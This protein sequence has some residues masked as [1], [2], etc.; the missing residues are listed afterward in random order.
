VIDLA[1]VSAGGGSI[2]WV[3]RG[4]SIKVGPASAGAVPGPAAY[5]R[6]GTEATV[7]DANIVLGYLDRKALLGGRLP[8][9]LAGAE[10]AISRVGAKMGFNPVETA[11]RIIEVVDANMAEALRIVSVERGYDPRSFALI[12]FGGAGPV[13]AAALAEELSIPEVIIPPA[14]G[15]FSALGLVASDLKRDYARTLYAE[16]EDLEPQR[17]EAV[18]VSMASS[19]LAML[20]DAR[21]PEAQREIR[22]F[23]D[24]RY[25]RQAYELTVPIPEGPIT[26]ATFA[27]IAAAF[28]RR[29]EQTYGH[30]NPDEPVTLVTL[31]LTALGHLPR[32]T[33]AQPHDPTKRSVRE[34]EVWFRKTGFVTTK[35]H[36]R[37]GLAPGDTLAGPAIIEAMD[38]TTVVPPDWIAVV[39]DYGYMR[40]T[41]NALGTATF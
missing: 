19:G 40:L 15:A 7:S 12:A 37:E 35:V 22:R 11:S 36:W 18:L 25:R 31:R 21:V 4:G 5:G 28:H 41:Q 20:A 24:V 2:A 1:E 27:E 16:L 38:S 9:D 8:I 39:D 26:A 10:A 23:A 30:A 29:H 6:G 14:P 32:L 34:R 33:L 13:H 17:V 3:D